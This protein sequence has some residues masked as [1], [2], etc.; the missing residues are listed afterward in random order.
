MAE[1]KPGL[2]G[3][4]SIAVTEQM[5]ANALGSGLADVLATP[6][7]VALMEGAACKALEGILLPELGSVGTMVQIYHTAPTPVGMKV[8]AKACLENV[9]GRRLMFS[10]EAWDEK[11]L[12]GEG[13]HE[14]FVVNSQSFQEK[15]DGKINA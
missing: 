9:D 7:L 12:V 15:A 1:I 13:K 10:V 6:Y 2:M 14:R 4:L 5:T 3:E 8:T 11:E